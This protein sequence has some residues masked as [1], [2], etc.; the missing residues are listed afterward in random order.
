MCVY[1]WLLVQLMLLQHVITEL[2]DVGHHNGLNRRPL[3]AV[4]AN[5]TLEVSGALTWRSDTLQKKKRGEAYTFLLVV[6]IPHSY[7][8][9]D[10]STRV[11]IQIDSVYCCNRYGII[12]H[13]REQLEQVAHPQAFTTVDLKCQLN[14]PQPTEISLQRPQT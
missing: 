11:P 8:T 5:P 6:F 3:E 9:K 14:S 10:C 13:E 4:V 7:V 1:S 2:L 12:L